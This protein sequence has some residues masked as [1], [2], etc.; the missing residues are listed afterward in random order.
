M[1]SYIMDTISHYY[2]YNITSI[3]P[4]PKNNWGSIIWNP[5]R[6][7]LDGNDLVMVIPA[8]FSLLIKLRKP[9]TSS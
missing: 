9:L 5:R 3:S 8:Y 7:L 1:L 6:L 4:V 2:K